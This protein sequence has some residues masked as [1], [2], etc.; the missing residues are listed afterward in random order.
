MVQTSDKV[1]HGTPTTK[2]P[3]SGRPQTP[4]KAPWTAEMKP[5]E[6]EAKWSARKVWFKFSVKDH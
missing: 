4:P 5:D 2:P 6:R 3:D 1:Q